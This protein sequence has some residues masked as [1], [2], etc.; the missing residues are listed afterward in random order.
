[1][2]KKNKQEHIC[3]ERE[4]EISFFFFLLLIKNIFQT[5]YMIYHR[6]TSVLAGKMCIR[7]VI[8]FCWHI[9]F[10]FLIL[11]F[12]IKWER[13]SSTNQNWRRYFLFF[14]IYRKTMPYYFINVIWSFL[15]NYLHQS[16]LFSFSQ[17]IIQLKVFLTPNFLSI[18]ESISIS[19][20]PDDW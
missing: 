4:S 18:D 2:L 5:R 12:F 16:E 11:Y 15:L 14:I 8:L 1:M 20:I 3:N 13:E 9:N 19:N 7:N 10:L 6:V 17:D